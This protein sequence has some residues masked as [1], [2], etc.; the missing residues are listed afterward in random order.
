MRPNPRLSQSE[1]ALEKSILCPVNDV[2]INVVIRI[3]RDGW[4]CPHLFEEPLR[5]DVLNHIPKEH[6]SSSK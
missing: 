3:Q 1:R 4:L 5:V 2:E 6:T